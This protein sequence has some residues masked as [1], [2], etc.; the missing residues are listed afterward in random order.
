MPRP[1]KNYRPIN[2][3]TS[4]PLRFSAEGIAL[5]PEHAEIFK[6][7]CEKFQKR[8]LDRFEDIDF[9]FPEEI[10]TNLETSQVIFGKD[11]R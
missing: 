3:V 6:E 5:T 10:Y 9:E 4:N 1:I 7:E 2:R 11:E 8:L